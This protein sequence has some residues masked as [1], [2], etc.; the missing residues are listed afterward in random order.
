MKKL[1]FILSLYC[2]F[3]TF[4]QSKEI[5]HYITNEINW[6]ENDTVYLFGNNVKFREHPNTDANNKVLDTLPIGAELR[7]IEVSKKT[8]NYNGIDYPWV[9]VQ[10]DYEIGY[11]LSGLIANS[12]L[13]YQGEEFYI[14]GYKKPSDNP[15]DTN[16]VTKIRAKK[17]NDEVVEQ[18]IRFIKNHV[19]F[20]IYDAKGLE[21]VDNV[22]RISTLTESCGDTSIENYFT[23]SK[24]NGFQLIFGTN[25]VADGGYSTVEEIIFPSDKFGEND[26][27]ILLDT[28]YDYADDE[29]LISIEYTEKYE[30]AWP[31]ENI[32]EKIKKAL[33]RK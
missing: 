18:E 19:Y 23:F 30:F 2:S 32:N 8:Y 31:Q 22:V 33:K 24:E 15:F 16:V 12:K 28:S 21:Y 17:S 11:V 14:L 4:G 6:K 26:K 1:L 9:M 13:E 10:H 5:S 3:F 29:E 7:V 20:S 27:I 25:I